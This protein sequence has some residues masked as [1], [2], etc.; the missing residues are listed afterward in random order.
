MFEFQNSCG[1]DLA[2]D[3]RV[4]IRKQCALEEDEQSEPEPKKRIMTASK[5]RGLR[6]TEADIKVFED[7]DSKEQ[8]ASAG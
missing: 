3:Y 5:L 2:L 4:K 7:N 6:L 1:Y 8:Q